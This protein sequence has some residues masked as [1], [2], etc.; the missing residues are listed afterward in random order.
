MLISSKGQYAL[1]M[2][3]DLSIHGDGSSVAVKTIAKR[4]GLSE[5]YLE[6]VISTL[7]RAGLLRSTRGP[8]GGYRL[9]KDPE[10]YTVGMIFRATEGNLDATDSESFRDDSPDPELN[11]VVDR[12][13]TQ[14]NGSIN[15]VLDEITL[16][17][18]TKEYNDQSDYI[19]LI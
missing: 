11:T 17:D 10:C 6:Q 18:L 9:A 19:Y 15:N 8:K 2:M 14:L 12:V 7:L 13:F 1:R 16:E 5:K 3:L 4:Q